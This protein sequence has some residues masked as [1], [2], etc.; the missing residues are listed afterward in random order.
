M[1]TELV[2][3]ALSDGGMEAQVRCW[4]DPPYR[5]RLAIHCDLVRQASARSGYLSFDG[6]DRNRTGQSAMAESF[7][8]TL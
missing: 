5:L 8:A 3:D 6:K 1:R 2:V 7:I 4:A